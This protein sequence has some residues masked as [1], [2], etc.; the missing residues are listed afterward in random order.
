MPGGLFTPEAL[1]TLRAQ[2]LDA[3]PQTAYVL[4]PTN[5]IEAGG[6]ARPTWA[7]ARSFFCRLSRQTSEER[8]DETRRQGVNDNS[9]SFPYDQPPLEG[10][11]LVI[12]VDDGT[13]DGPAFT[14][15]FRVLSTQA[16]KTFDTR[17][18]ALLT[19][20]DVPGIDPDD[21]IP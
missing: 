4:T 18:V 15:V 16:E 11:E 13:V 17:R 19:T 3:M 7:L 21:Y 1:A 20:S 8:S 14:R 2:Q 9:L 6:V 12:V 5:A 10:N